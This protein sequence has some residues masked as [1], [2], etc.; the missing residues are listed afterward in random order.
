MPAAVIFDVDGTL[1]DSVGQHARAWQDVFAAFGHD[2]DLDA[3]RM[4]IGKGGDQ[5]LPVF[6]DDATIEAQGEQISKRRA[7]ILKAHYL[8]SIQP[9]ADVRALFERLRSDGVKIALASSAKRD[10]LDVYVKRADIEGLFDVATSSDDA[11]KSKP[12]PDIF[13]AALERLGKPPASEVIVVGDSPY[14][15]EAAAKA[16][17]Q[18]VGLLGG[19][20]SRG[21]PEKM[22]AASRS[23]AILRICL[24]RMSSRRFPPV[25]RSLSA[26]LLH[27]KTI[28]PCCRPDPGNRRHRS[29][30]REPGAPS[31]AAPRLSAK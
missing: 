20:L 17:M 13:N 9:F 6:L 19:G 26:E 8:D 12:H 1:V 7:D 30:S 10:E 16:G 24:Q 15:A 27:G 31:S 11:D 25:R 2:I 22:P 28:Q 5:L 18:T 21:R 23:I 29:L 3:I 14:D 4:Q